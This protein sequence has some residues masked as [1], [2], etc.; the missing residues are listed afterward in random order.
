[1]HD[2]RAQRGQPRQRGGLVEVAH[3]RH[4]AAGAQLVH[5]GRRRR[6]RQQAHARAQH[7]RHAQAHVAAADDEDALAAEARRQGSE[8]VLVRGQNTRA[9]A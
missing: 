2:A 3:Q 6:Q 7:A 4:D 1:V 5:A 8:G 9:D